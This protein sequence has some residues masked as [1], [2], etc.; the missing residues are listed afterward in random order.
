MSMEVGVRSWDLLE[1]AAEH[2]DDS[3]AKHGE[4]DDL[5]T[6]ADRAGVGDGHRCGLGRVV[7]ART[8]RHAAAEHGQEEQGF[9]AAGLTAA[10]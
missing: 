8:D 1:E 10:V 7:L 9:E 4:A 2:G 5:E 3:R 6:V